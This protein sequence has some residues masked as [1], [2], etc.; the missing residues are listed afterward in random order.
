MIPVN[1]KN[2]QFRKVTPCTV[3]SVPT[4]QSKLAQKGAVPWLRPLVA[5]LS[6]RRHQFNPWPLHVGFVVDKLTTDQGFLPV[7]QLSSAINIPTLLHTHAF[8]YDGSYIT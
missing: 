5:S 3:L 2:T 7:Y 4:L 1:M 8:I 6:T